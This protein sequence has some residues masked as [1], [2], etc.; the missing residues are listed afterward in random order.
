MNSLM[1]KFCIKMVIC[2][3]LADHEV[4]GL[5][6]V[7]NGDAVMS[8][9]PTNPEES[10]FEVQVENSV[11]RNSLCS[12][13][14]NQCMKTV[15]DKVPSSSELSPLHDSSDIQA[16]TVVNLHEET[17]SKVGPNLT[18]EIDQQTKE[19]DVEVVLAKQE[20]HDLFCPNCKS[21]I[22][23]RVILKKRKRNIQNLDNKAKRDKFDTV[24]SPNLVNGSAH[25]ANQGDHAN[26]TSDITTSLEPPADNDHPEREPEVFRCLSCLSFFIPSGKCVTFPEKQST[27]WSLILSFDHFYL[28]GG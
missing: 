25:E 4:N 12:E 11:V 2:A 15:D 13:V 5:D 17:N 22:T 27:L 21:C 14:N 10:E 26:V 1:W 9:C 7:Q 19:F 6:R 16:T 23:K 28:A 8:V 3:M 18:Q 24:D 20:T